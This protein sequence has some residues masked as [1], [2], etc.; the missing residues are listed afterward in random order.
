MTHAGTPPCRPMALVLLML[1]AGC[2]DPA[3]QGPPPLTR[4]K[5][6]AAQFSDFAPKVTLTGT[7]SAQVQSDLAFR[8][9]GKMIERTV[10]VGD[11]VTADQ[12]LA[13]LDPQAQQA[14][15][16][17]AKAAVQSAEAQLK[18][19]AATFDRQKT[20]L[21]NGFTT[22]RDHDS[23]EEAMR[24]AQALLDTAQAQLTS[25]QDQI[26]Y[27]ELKA[28]ASG[29]ITARYAEAGQVVEQARAI[30]T[31]AEDGSRDAVFDVYEAIFAEAERDRSI[32]I[33]LVSDPRV[34]ASANVREV[35]PAVD[36]SNGT[37]RVKTGLVATPPAMTLGA[38]VTGTGQ[39][40]HRQVI[41]LPPSVLFELDGKPAVWVV[42][43]V[44]HAVALKPIVVERYVIGAVIV[45]SGIAPGD[46]V[47]T[48]GI[49]LLRPG[50]QVAIAEGLAP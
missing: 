18:Q 32:E 42:D 16:E 34:T 44:R 5:V 27:T 3:P 37:V 24:S 11:H 50:Q 2:T 47:A 39:L 48:A 1:L 22:R 25:A 13:K 7:I 8:I 10:D 19:A 23:A 36:S 29:I 28:G 38:I 26:A 35:S 14:N 15:L 33:T 30:F 49:Q 9:S 45:T 6:I 17:S 46:L 40:K 43:P 4:I 20:L 12:V 31:I 21:A 41:K